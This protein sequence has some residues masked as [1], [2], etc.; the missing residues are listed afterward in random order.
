MRRDY[1][2]IDVIETGRNIKQVMLA[3]NLTV[4]DI[5]HFLGLASPQSIYHWFTGKS[6]PTLDNIYALSELFHMPVDM[7]LRGSRKYVCT[8]FWDPMNR[9]LYEYFERIHSIA[10]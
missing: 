9:R 2:V 8:A 1:P 7:I 5:Q 3:K 10:A 6:M 4:K